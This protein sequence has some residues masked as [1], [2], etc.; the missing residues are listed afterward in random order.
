MEQ[1]FAP[2]EDIEATREKY[3]D[4]SWHLTQ[5][6]KPE[7]NVGEG[8]LNEEWKQHKTVELDPNDTNRVL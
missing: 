8:A 1:K 5:T 7:W 6:Q 4:V 2:F 3:E